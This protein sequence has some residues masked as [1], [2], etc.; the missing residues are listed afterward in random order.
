MEVSVIGE[1]GVW[2]SELRPREDRLQKTLKIKMSSFYLGNRE[3][4]Q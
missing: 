1:L 4:G 3:K 2:V